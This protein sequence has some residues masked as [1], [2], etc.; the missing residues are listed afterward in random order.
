MVR[1]FNVYHGD[2]LIKSGLSPL[3]LQQ[4]TPDTSYDLKIS[5]SEFM[6]ESEKVDVPLFKTLPENILRPLKTSDFT[7]IKGATL[8]DDMNAIK[9][10]SDGKERIQCYTPATTKSVLTK[11]L[12]TGKTYRISAKVKFD[13]GYNPTANPLRT[14]VLVLTGMSPSTR[15]IVTRVPI[16]VSTT[17]YLEFSGEVGITGDT[18]IFTNYYLIMQSDTGTE[19]FNGTIRLKDLE[20]REVI[21]SP[22]IVQD[23]K[24][25]VTSNYVIYNGKTT[26]KYIVNQTYEVK[27]TGTK[28]DTQ[29]FVLYLNNGNNRK[30]TLSRIEGTNTYTGIFKF[31]EGDAPEAHLNTFT[32]L[33]IPNGT[34]GEVKIDNLEMKKIQ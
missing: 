32:V 10:T 11:P 4:L 1:T 30:A 23:F 19:R 15:L 21:E 28:P 18:S 8:S 7:T 9:I 33:Q 13:E 27:L 24:P 20:L 22:N 12:E 17:E 2:K 6:S 16:P 5:A 14:F 29:E 26:E 3:E 31:N 34:I 25:V